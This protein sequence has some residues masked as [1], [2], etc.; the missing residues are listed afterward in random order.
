MT[1][2]DDI[3][4]AIA[5]LERRREAIDHSLSSLRDTLMLIRND[6]APDTPPAGSSAPTIPGRVPATQDVEHHETTT[7]S[8]PPTIRQILESHMEADRELHTSA[9]LKLLRQ[10]GSTAAESSVRSQLHKFAA[11][12]DGF[13]LKSD[14]PATFIKPSARPDTRTRNEPGLQ[15]EDHEQQGQP[16]A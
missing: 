16:L 15:F 11:S 13:L 4:A 1:L 10:H 7:P 2:I 6:L 3:E 9:I 12:S 8:T 14:K 5:A